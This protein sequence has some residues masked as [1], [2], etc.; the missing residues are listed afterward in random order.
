M[1]TALKFIVVT[2]L[3]PFA[4]MAQGYSALIDLEGKLTI[5][6]TQASSITV[7]CEEL[8]GF[9]SINGLAP[10]NGTLECGQLR[11][12]EFQGSVDADTIDLSRITKANFRNFKKARLFGNQ[13]IDH[14]IG[15]YRGDVI[16]G[17]TEDDRIEG[18]G[19]NDRLNG[20]TGNDTIIGGPGNDTI[21]GASGNDILNGG[22]GK[23]RI[24]AG[25]GNDRLNGGGGDDTLEAGSGNDRLNGGPGTDSG[26]AGSGNDTLI[27]IENRGGGSLPN[28]PG[29]PDLSDFF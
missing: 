21:R 1:S 24:I 2:L 5:T 13:G 23:D 7:Q 3:T 11:N 26:D 4:L 9:V 14:L 6:A 17:G 15:T 10:D 29:N 20:S 12:I 18:L 16:N 8:S 19:G 27:S 28:V 22:G 25:S